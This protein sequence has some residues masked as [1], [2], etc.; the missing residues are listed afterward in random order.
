MRMEYKA[1]MQGQNMAGYREVQETRY[2]SRS[3]ES[4][5]QNGAYELSTGDVR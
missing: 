4:G 1:E 5:S 2:E 3:T